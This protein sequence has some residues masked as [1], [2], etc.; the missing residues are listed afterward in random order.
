MGELAAY[1]LSADIAFVG[2]SLVDAGCQN[3]IEPISCRVPTLFRLLQLQLRPSLQG[4]VEAKPPSV[5]KPPEAWYRTTRQYLDDETLR[6][7]LISYTEQFISQ[8]QGAS[9]KIAKAIADC[10]NQR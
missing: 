8:H 1:Y 6:Q 7:Q 2:G 3:I 10:L 4:A 5:S 9:A